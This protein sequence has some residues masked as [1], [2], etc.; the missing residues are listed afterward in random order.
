MLDFLTE[1]VV[2]NPDVIPVRMDLIFIKQLLPFLA[3]YIPKWKGFIP[4]EFRT[5]Y[6][7]FTID[8]V[9]LECT[10]VSNRFRRVWRYWRDIHRRSPADAPLSHKDWIIVVLSR[11]KSKEGRGDE[12]LFKEE[13]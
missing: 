5:S 7:R 12:A 3:K 11:E 4:D 1:T 6:S 8:V 13:I 10:I 2:T 9:A